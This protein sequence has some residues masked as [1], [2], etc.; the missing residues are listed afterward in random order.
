M[1]L[2]VVTRKGSYAT[3]TEIVRGESEDVVPPL[4]HDCIWKSQTVEELT[5]DG[6]V[7]VIYSNSYVE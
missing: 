5:P 1:K 6:P 3:E 4:L 2:F 7:G